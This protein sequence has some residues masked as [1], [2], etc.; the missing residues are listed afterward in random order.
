MKKTLIL[1][2]ILCSTAYASAQVGV[3]VN[4]QGEATIDYRYKD[5]RF[6]MTFQP[7]YDIAQSMMPTVSY[8][9]V[10]KEKYNLYF[11]MILDNLDQSD[12]LRIPVGIDFYP[13]SDKN[14]SLYTELVPYINLNASSEAIRGNL[15]I[16]Y[17]FNK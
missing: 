14:L 3:A 5:F 9:A 6:G 12:Y 1:L 7:A 13:L 8:E 10:K 16:R 4:I 15:G 2:F 17:R 11:G